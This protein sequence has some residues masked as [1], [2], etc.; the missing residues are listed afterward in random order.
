VPNQ[1]PQG[2]SPPQP[3][4]THSG[5]RSS[6]PVYVDPFSNEYVAALRR[7]QELFRA[8]EAAS[9]NIATPPQPSADAVVVPRRHQCRNRNCARSVLEVTPCCG[10]CTDRCGCVCQRCGNCSVGDNYRKRFTPGHF[11]NVCRQ[12]RGVCKCRKRKG[13]LDVEQLGVS[14]RAHINRLE[15]MMGI[16]VELGEWGTLTREFRAKNFQYQ[17]VRDGSVQPSGLEMVVSPL[18]G[19]A[20]LRGMFELGEL[21]AKNN[22]EVNDSCGLHVHVNAQDLGW[23]ALRR[24][25]ALYVACEQQIYRYVIS[26]ERARNCHYYKPASDVWRKILT[27]TRDSTDANTI[28]H[29]ILGLLYPDHM[30]PNLLTQDKTALWKA[31]KNSKYGG[32][33]RY[34]GLNLH[35]FFY[36][37]TVEFRMFDG[38]TKLEDLV[39]WP[40]VCGWM[41]EKAINLTDN[42]IA[43]ITSLGDFATQHLPS[44]VRNW[45]EGKLAREPNPEVN[46]ELPPVSPTQLPMS[47]RGE[48]FMYDPISPNNAPDEDEDED[49]DLFDDE[50]EEE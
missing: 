33:S 21:L 48:T 43:K 15:R 6:Y 39:N 46:D 23:W 29:R 19:D 27:E 17:V 9:A 34:Y 2:D 10:Y 11:C 14:R 40:L 49:D 38:T 4:Y 35:S 5:W 1:E 44:S 28:K 13:F 50:D 30:N 18:R 45:V 42:E 3:Q 16:E 31:V 32:V 20:F 25:V 36:R 7:A 37:G 47:L 8:G 41:V 12:C 24:L 22:C 26:P